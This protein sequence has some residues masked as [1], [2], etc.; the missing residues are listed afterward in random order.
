MLTNLKRDSGLSQDDWQALKN[1]LESDLARRRLMMPPLAPLSP[2]QPYSES[3]TASRV[4][5][6]LSKLDRSGSEQAMS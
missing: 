3:I 1:E 2:I 5:R 6:L 4:V